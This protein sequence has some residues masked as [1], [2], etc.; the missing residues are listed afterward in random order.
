M[1]LSENNQPDAFECIGFKRPSSWSG[2]LLTLFGRRREKTCL[3]GFRQLRFKPACSA[4]ETSSKNEISLVASLDIVLYK[5]RITKALIRLRGC[6]GWSAPVL[7]ANPRRQ[8]FS[9]QGPFYLNAGSRYISYTIKVKGWYF[10]L[11]VS[12]H[13]IN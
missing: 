11:F 13:C 4:T 7:F 3:R 1:C 6:A 2:K 8:V 9:R 12:N 5:T 10:M